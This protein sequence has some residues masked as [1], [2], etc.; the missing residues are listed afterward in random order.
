[1]PTDHKQLKRRE[2]LL[3][4]LVLMMIEYWLVT[5]SY[6]YKSSET[7][8]SYISFA[9]TIASILLAV[10]A[11]IYSFVQ[12]DAQQNAS[13]TMLTQTDSLRT[14]AIGLSTSGSIITEQVSKITETAERLRLLEQVLDLAN[15][16]LQGIESHITGIKGSQ[17]AVIAA[18]QSFQAKTPNTPNHAKPHEGPQDMIEILFRR[19]SFDADLF[20]Y[21]LSKFLKLDKN[22][23]PAF[24]KAIDLLYIAPTAEVLSKISPSSAT[25]MAITKS[26]TIL[27]VARALGILRYENKDFYL[28]PEFEES[29]HKVAA[30]TQISEEP[31]VKETI[32]LIDAAATKLA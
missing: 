22:K 25:E 16:K 7:L 21:A 28:P 18:I 31:L 14:T 20:G 30:K 23:Q 10:I 29:I 4:I 11:I 3:V 6:E 27:S 2:W 17:D 8:I 1:M 13:A 12:A 19:T 5:T 15:Q 9:A 32:I 26:Y 24:S